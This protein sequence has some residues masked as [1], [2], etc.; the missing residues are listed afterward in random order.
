MPVYVVQSTDFISPDRRRYLYI[1]TY[2]PT[3]E[4]LA[5][6]L[7]GGP[8]AVRQLFAKMEN[9]EFVVRDSRPFLLTSAYVHHCYPPDHPFVEFEAESGA[10]PV[11]APTA[12]PT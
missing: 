8:V 12:R 3:L 6:D 9:G 10:A 2:H 11:V 7:R 4:T 5:A 1:E